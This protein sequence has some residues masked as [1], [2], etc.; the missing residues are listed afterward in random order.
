M[1]RL[2]APILF[3]LLALATLAQKPTTIAGN[4]YYGNEYNAAKNVTVSLYDSQR[5]LIEFQSTTDAGQFRFGDLRRAQYFIVIDAPGCEHYSTDVDVSMASD[6]DVIIYLKSIA[7]PNGNLQS[8]T[9]SVHEL[10]MP[11]KARDFME[12]GKKKLYENKNPQAALADF[13]QAVAAAPEYYE[14]TYQLAMAQLTLGN[15]D[16]AESFF[17]KSIDLSNNKYPE[18][19]IGLGAVLLDT[20]KISEADQSIRAAVR[21]NPTLW[22][23]HYELGR[24]LLKQNRLTEA[25]SSAEEARLLAPGAPIVYRLLS[26]IH[27][28]QKN[29]PALLEDL[30]TY[31]TL[32]PD[33]PAGQR[34]KQLRDQLQQKLTPTST[35]PASP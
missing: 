7:K 30:D 35:T 17:R 8:Q 4:V 15:R 11:A 28:Q 25:Q 24:L 19:Q 31:L 14:A 12:S 1:S 16:D 9:V 13:Q 3:L 26:N 10:T 23:G 33:S 34:A 22:L 27:L 32:D 5:Q 18:A 29:Y 2:L 20:G 21:Q 6:K